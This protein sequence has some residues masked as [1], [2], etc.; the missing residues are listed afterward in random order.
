[1]S[2]NS[3]Q[4]K[5]QYSKGLIIVFDDAHWIADTVAN[6][7]HQCPD[8]PVTYWHAAEMAIDAD[9]EPPEALYFAFCSASAAQRQA[10]NSFEAFRVIL[11]WLTAWDRRVVNGNVMEMEG[12][13]TEQ[14]RLCRKV[15][16]PVPRTLIGT[17]S[18]K[19]S[20]LVSAQLPAPF[21][22]KP[23]RGGSGSGVRLFDTVDEFESGR[24]TYFVENP[25]PT[26]LYLFQ[27]YLDRSCGFYRAEF[28]G[29]KFLYLAEILVDPESPGFNMCPCANK[30]ENYRLSRQFEHPIRQRMEQFIQ[31]TDAENIAFEFIRNSSGQACV[32]DI[33]SNTS[34]N[35]EAEKHYSMPS[36]FESVATYLLQLLGC[37]PES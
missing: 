21:I 9:S 15:G 8:L 33:N 26:G 3:C 11:G 32:I 27:E 13:K 6:L 5:P 25:C 23:D 22:L 14:I 19:T 30:V 12:S 20:S 17:V 28:V 16:L 2:T 7:Q 35:V 18:V 34:F 29:K 1:M 24:T 4:L 31:A 37:R 10:P 36:G